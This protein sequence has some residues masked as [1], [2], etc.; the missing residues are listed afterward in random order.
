MASNPE[1]RSDLA[2]L[3]SQLRDRG[4]V[5]CALMRLNPARPLLD[6]TID[7]VVIFSAVGV[8][9]WLSHLMA[10]LAVLVIA[11]R[12]RALGN[13]LHD[14][15]H[16]NLCRNRFSNDL[17]ARILV[18]PLLFASL[19][20]YR[21]AHFKH[22]LALGDDRADPDLLPIPDHPPTH[23]LASY[24]RHLCSWR[25]WLGSAGGHLI[26]RQVRVASKFYILAWWIT[27]VGTLL[28]L[29]GSDFTIAFVL[30]WLLA[31]ATFFHLIT[32]FREMCDHYGLCPGGVFSFTRDMACHGIWRELI[33]PRNNGYHLTHH[34]LPAVP[35]YHLPDAHELLRQTPA[36]QERS[37]V[38]N[39]YFTD[40][41][42]VVCAWQART[43]P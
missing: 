10:P 13:I 15:G 42:A 11:N 16:R 2:A 41:N 12:Q 23:W 35:Y 19:T 4:S 6:V 29:A 39:S 8:V 33:H 26:A 34:L 3:R 27:G 25:A 32:T 17:A 5:H 9:V 31:R 30:L 28:V 14:A 40:E 18:A 37:Q 24:A 21:Q 38:C 22:H 43:R 20:S 1:V 7:G 36:F